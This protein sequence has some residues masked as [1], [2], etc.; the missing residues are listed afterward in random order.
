MNSALKLFLLAAAFCI[1]DIGGAD[2][3][4]QTFYLLMAA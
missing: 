2:T 4:S 1:P 3:H